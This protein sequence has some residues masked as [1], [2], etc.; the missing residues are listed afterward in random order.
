[1]NI[2]IQ[3]IKPKLIVNKINVPVNIIITFLLQVV[4]T[5]N[6]CVNILIVFTILLLKNV[7]NPI[8]AAF[9]DLLVAGL[10][11]ASKNSLNI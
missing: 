10:A 9:K 6:V 11:V 4:K 7:N 8:V 3:K 1:M 5:L 2:L